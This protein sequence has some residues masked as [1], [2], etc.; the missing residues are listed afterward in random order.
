VTDK[1]IPL[2]K[3]RPKITAD[4]RPIDLSLVDDLTLLVV[5]VDAI[6]E[7]KDRIH[8]MN[9]MQVADANSDPNVRFTMAGVVKRMQ[10]QMTYIAIA[11]GG[12]M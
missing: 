5:F 10:Q 11:C 4:R 12:G 6:N 9:D 7:V 3:P 1:I 8:T 2:A